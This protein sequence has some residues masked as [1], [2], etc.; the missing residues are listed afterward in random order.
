MAD[1]NGLNSP[2]KVEDKRPQL[3]QLAVLS[4]QLKE[5]T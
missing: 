5:A 1:F 4:E 3:G 2:V